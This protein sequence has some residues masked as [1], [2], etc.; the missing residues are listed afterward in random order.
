MGTVMSRKGL[1]GFSLIELMITVVIVGVL[2]AIAIPN[3]TRYMV[4]GHRTEAQAVL[5]DIAQREQQFFLDNR[6]YT[7]T[8]SNLNGFVVPANV[9]KFYDVTV[10]LPIPTPIPPTFTATA[11]PKGSQSADGNL[12]IDNTGVKVP[13]DKW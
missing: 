7:G 6:A 3:Y 2:A 11:A 5:M 10:A 8:L 12:S 4:R 1:R 13:A 9:A